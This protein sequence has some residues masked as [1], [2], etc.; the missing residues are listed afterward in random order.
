MAKKQ[1]SGLKNHNINKHMNCAFENSKRS[2]LLIKTKH[3][4]SHG[5]SRLT[6]KLFYTFVRYSLYHLEP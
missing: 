5:S 4:T 2:V 6:L 3:V 1:P